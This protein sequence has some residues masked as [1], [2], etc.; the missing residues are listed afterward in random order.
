MAKKNQEQ[1][2]EKRIAKARERV[3]GAY[4]R[5]RRSILAPLFENVTV[6]ECE[7]D[8]HAPLFGAVDPD[9]NTLW[10]N[11]HR[12]PEIG[13][14]EWT[15]LIAHL[16]LHLGLNHAKRPEGR[17]LQLWTLAC[18][19]AAENLACGFKLGSPP[20]DF[21]VDTTYA[22]MREEA[23]YELLQQSRRGRMTLLTCAGPNQPDIV[24]VT[25][26]SLTIQP[27]NT[28]YK[29]GGDRHDYDAL[30]AEGIRAGV[31]QAVFEAAETLGQADA[32]R[33]GAWRPLENAKKW[34]MNELPLLGALAAQMR[35]LPDARLCERMDIAVAAVNPW[36]GEIYFH[37]GR[38]LSQE[39][40]LFVYVHELLHVA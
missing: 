30:L 39:E 27:Y 35:I 5:I 9:H 28:L 18:E 12:R 37:T 33:P 21:P 25:G 32:D 24:H 40:V 26:Y 17:D 8:A 7:N 31:E 38:G 16:L 22:G 36:L 19:H 3:R 2:A 29:A 14:A 34:V 23:I 13:E 1:P 20:H 10:L 15:F 4:A 6:R 11:P